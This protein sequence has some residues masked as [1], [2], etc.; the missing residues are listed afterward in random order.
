MIHY[1][2]RTLHC[3]YNLKEEFQLKTYR[4]NAVMAGLFYF[5]GTAFGI[6]SAIIG[7]EVIASTVK[8]KPLSGIVL[9]DLVVNDSSHLLGGSFL[10]LL[11]GISLVAMTLFLYPIFKKDSE[12]LAM[13]MLIFRGAMEGAWYFITTISF[14]VLFAIGEEYVATGANSIVLQS[15]ASI[16]HKFQGLLGPVGTILFLIGATCLYVSFYRTQ[17]IPRW[18]SVWGLVGIIPYMAYALLHLFG[19]DSSIGMYLQ[20]PLGIQEMVMAFWLIIKGFNSEAVGKLIANDRS[21]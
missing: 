6:A 13:G 21:L 5:L 17:L 9:I 20:I 1:V 2:Y 15:M 3:R 10:I 14:L 19:I 4:I 16:V 11:M 8:T 12:E 18:L 7:G